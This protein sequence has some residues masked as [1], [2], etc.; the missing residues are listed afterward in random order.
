MSDIY[1]ELISK[2]WTTQDNENSLV[3][4]D[5]PPTYDTFIRECLLKNR[6]ALFTASCGFMDDWP[7]ITEWLNKDRTE[8]D[9]DRLINLYGHMT[10]P[11]T[12]C[13]STITEYSSDDN[14]LTMHF[15]EFVS[16]WRNNETAAE[17]YCKDWHL[18]KMS[19]ETK[20]LFYS[21]PTYFQSDWL[22]EKCLAENEDDFRFVYM[23]GDGT[24]TP[25]HMDVLGTYSWS[26]NVCGRKRWRFSKP[27]SIEF[28][29]EPG[30][31]LF[32]PS[33]WYHDV[34]NIGFTISINHN[35]FNAF[36]ILRIWKHLC[37]TL[38]DIEHRI[39][40]CRSVMSDTW[41]VHCQLILQANEGLN[42]ASLYK[43]LYIVA[44]R[45]MKENQDEYKRFDLWMINKLIRDILHHSIFLYAV[46]LDTFPERPKALLK[47]IHSFIEKQKQ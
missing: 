22:N 11:I 21:T 28:I 27:H 16:L 36:N 1:T 18:Q 34:T 2:D 33:E 13:S 47:Q 42:F 10:V 6:P 40:D 24:N 35:W 5:K 30:D 3:R 8:P 7:C 15:D 37:A 19:D 4:Y 14:K 20:P 45:R 32:V 29:Q 41:H 17:Y 31:I 39:E 23:G 46:D 26:A 25:L 43:L 12:K 38:E 9:F 44:Q